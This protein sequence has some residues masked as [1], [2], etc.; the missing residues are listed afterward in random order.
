MKQKPK[1]CKGITAETKGYG[2][3]KETLHRVHGLGKMCGCYAN[4]LLNTDAGKLKMQRAT[5]KATK[6]SRELKRAEKEHKERMRLP[7]AL[8]KT[9][10]LFNEYIRLRD[11]GRPCISE[12]IQWK[13]DF[14]AGHFFSVKQYSALRFD[15]DNCHAQSILGNRMK[16]GN[17][18]DYAINLPF[19]IGEERFAS[20]LKRAERSKQ[21]VKKWTL[22]ELALIRS[23]LKKKIKELEN[24]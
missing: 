4:W 3:G 20:L 14:D 17:F 2:C 7:E 21:T 1:A 22:E 12:Q 9:Q 13:N 19:R 15:E 6:N 18:Q 10:K 5:L 11:I 8:N 24:K 23:E 16:E